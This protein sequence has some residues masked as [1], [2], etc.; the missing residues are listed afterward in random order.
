M[1]PKKNDLQQ[2]GIIKSLNIINAVSVIKLSNFMKFKRIAS[3]PYTCV[4]ELPH[5]SKP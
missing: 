4:V 5:Y 3:L 2:I 1:H